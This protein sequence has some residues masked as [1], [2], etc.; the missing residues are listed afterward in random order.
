MTRS[1]RRREKKKHERDFA[2][3]CRITGRYFPDF[4]QWLQE[5]RDPRKFWTYE[6]EVMLMTVI[7]KNICCIS[8]MRKMTDE[9]PDEGCV[10]NLCRILKVEPHEFLPHYVT[11]N[12]FLS[13]LDP[14]ELERLRKTMIRT[15]LRRRKFDGA[16]FLGKYWLVIFDATGLFHFSE[17]H[18]PHCLK[19]VLNKG[20]KE[21]KE[22]CYHHVL[23]AKLVPGEGF[24]ISI[25]TEF[26]ENEAEDVSKNDCETKAFKRLSERLKKEYPRLPVCVLADSLYASEPVF[27]KC[28]K[29]NKW[30]VLIRYKDGSIPSVAEE[31][32][33]IAG[34]GEAEE[35]YR[36]IVR[37]YPRKGKVKEKHHMEW[38]PDI[39]YRGYR[40]TLPVLETETETEGTGKKETKMFQWLTDLKVTGRNA[41]EFAAVGRSRWQIE[42]EGFNIQKNI[43]Y[44]IQHADSMNYNAMK[45]H[46]LL[47]QMADIMLQLYEKGCPGLREAKGDI[48]KISSDLLKS[49]GEQLTGEDILFI[50]AHGYVKAVT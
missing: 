20:T 34:M 15:L 50:R 4:I 18:C 3:F 46:Y 41:G 36:Q 42:N 1:E 26:M 6:T 22:V 39:D 32:R 40:L 24:V 14:K 49:F 16:K 47:T 48:K 29:E 17:R 9:F 43:R 33:S 21:E 19:K 5:V 12:E 2:V 44:D 31:Y 45:C 13:R 7:M 8:S 37:E 35:L 28:I 25:G 27:Q 30:H 23:E 38:V 10:E 11:V